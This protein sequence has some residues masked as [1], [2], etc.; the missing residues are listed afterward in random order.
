[1]TIT[2][3]ILARAAGKPHVSPGDVIFA[4]IDKV[5]LHDVRGLES[6]KFSVSGKKWGKNLSAFGIQIEYG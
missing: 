6:L 4:K 2:E 1:M 3:K 5:M